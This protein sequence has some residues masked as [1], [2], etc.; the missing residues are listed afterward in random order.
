MSVPQSRDGTRPSGNNAV[1][2]SDGVS[3]R[4]VT[5]I[6]YEVLPPPTGEM[7][8]NA[9]T[10]MVSGGTSIMKISETNTSPAKKPS[11]RAPDH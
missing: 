7:S 8:T 4:P 1:K 6:Q 3:S 2:Y 11:N 10:S 9:G 5:N